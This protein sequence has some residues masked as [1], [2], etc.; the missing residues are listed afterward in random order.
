V[1]R[2]SRALCK[3]IDVKSLISVSASL[4]LAGLGLAP[5]AAAQTANPASPQPA[6]EQPTTQPCGAPWDR[7]QQAKLPP[8]Q[9][10]PP[11]APIG[12]GSGFDP[13]PPGY[14]L[15]NGGND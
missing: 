11:A 6:I 5:L 12:M 4:L 7:Q 8:G 1:P 10:F 2:Q 9:T 14:G 15:Y 3:E 13:Y